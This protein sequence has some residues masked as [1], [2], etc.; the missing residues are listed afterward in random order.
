MEGVAWE[1][2]HP[3]FLIGY[4]GHLMIWYIRISTA[5]KDLQTKELSSDQLVNGE[6]ENLRSD[7]F[8]RK[9]G[10]AVPAKGEGMGTTLTTRSSYLSP[11]ICVDRLALLF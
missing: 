1:V 8:Q 11:L 10:A 9:L 2:S 3:R 6:C 4:C 7:W 5:R